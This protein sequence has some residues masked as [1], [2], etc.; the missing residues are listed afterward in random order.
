MPN[1]RLTPEPIESTGDIIAGDAACRERDRILLGKLAESGPRRQIWLDVS[2]EQVVAIVGKRGTGKSYSLGVLLEGFAA[3]PGNS[4]LALLNT[5]RAGLV[6]DIMD[7]FWSSQ[8]TLSDSGSSELRRQYQAMTRGGFTS[9]ALAVDVW[10]PAGFEKPAVDPPG[11]TSLRINAS[12]LSLDDWGSLFEVD[13]YAEPRGMLIADAVAHVG[14]DGY[15]GTDGAAVAA[16]A[17][18]SFGDLL[19][20]LEND[21]DILQNYQDVTLRSVRQRM[22]TYQS[23]ALFSGAGTPLTA[24]LRPFRVSVLMLARLPDAL[25]RVVVAVILRRVGRDRQEASIAQ[26]RLDLDSS[27]EETEVQRLQNLINS[28]IP[29]TWVMMD[30]AHVLAGANE[31]TVASEALVKFAKEGRNYGLSLA[32]ATQQPSALESRLMSQV[33]TLL[34]HQLTS[35]DDAA[36]ATRAMRSP[37]PEAIALDGVDSDMGKL[38]RRLSQGEAVFSCGNAPNLRRSCVFAVRPR[39][40]AHGGYEA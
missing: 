30:E 28:T 14:R 26:K 40:T 33:E 12:D 22:T 7:I 38:L 23:L 2:G 35:P 11:L 19:A 9:R 6:L 29:R 15:R 16:R 8:L 13:I 5:P 3:G 36:V 21:A 18:F 32:V 25:K 27:L 17:N 37:G 34:V 4:E 20:C 39:I 31:S 10:I 24:L 1:Y